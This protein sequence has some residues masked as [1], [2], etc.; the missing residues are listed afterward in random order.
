MW[1]YLKHMALPK[2]LEK[3]FDRVQIASYYDS[4][5]D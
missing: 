4:G 5:S 1:V 3:F 2:Y